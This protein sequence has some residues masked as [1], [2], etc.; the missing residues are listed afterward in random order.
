MKLS[1][2]V[3]EIPGTEDQF[4]KLAQLIKNHG[5][6]GYILE[7]RIKGPV[8]NDPDIDADTFIDILEHHKVI[9]AA[10]ALEACDK[11]EAPLFDGI[12]CDICEADSTSHKETFYKVLNLVEYVDE[13]RVGVKERLA[14]VT[15]INDQEYL[16]LIA[17]QVKSLDSIQVL[18]KE[19]REL[20]IQYQLI[21]FRILNTVFDVVLE[22]IGSDGRSDIKFSKPGELRNYI[23]EYKLWYNPENAIDQCLNYFTENTESGFVFI[24]NELKHDIWEEYIESKVKKSRSYIAATPGEFILK[25]DTNYINIFRSTHLCEVSKR[26]SFIYHFIY[27]IHGNFGLRTPR[28]PKTIKATKKTA[29]KL[30][31]KAVKKGSRKEPL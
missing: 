25:S 27:N 21:G 12:F 2:L 9:T 31:K 23:G 26:R 7:R 3:D 30:A 14:Q 28:L 6:N 24:V 5:L 20:E 11:C 22:S 15:P 18:P 10:Q 19:N 1:N 8:N 29:K 4:K 17:S 16:N 13:W